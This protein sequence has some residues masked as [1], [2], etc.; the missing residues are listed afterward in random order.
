MALYERVDSNEEFAESSIQEGTVIPEYMTATTDT[1]TP[2]D[3]KFHSEIQGRAPMLDLAKYP[4]GRFG[5]ERIPT[6][7]LSSVSGES[8]PLGQTVYRQGDS[9][10][11]YYGSAFNTSDQNGFYVTL[12]ADAVIEVTF[13]GTGLNVLL[14]YSNVSRTALASVDGGAEGS[15]I[16]NGTSTVLN[17]RNYSI[18]V[19]Q[20]AVSGLPLGIHTVKIRSSGSTNVVHGFEILNESTTI[21]IPE[22]SV[23]IEGKKHTLA[24]PTTTD[25]TTFDVETQDGGS[26]ITSTNKGG[27]VV[28]YIDTD[29]TIK[30]A[31]N[32][33]DSAQGNVGVDVDHSNEVVV[34][35]FNWREFGAGRA[36]DFSTLN[37]QSGADKAF[38]LDDGTTTLVGDALQ[39]SGGTSTGVFVNNGGFLTLTF[40][41][42]GLDV[43]FVEGPAGGTLPVTV[44]GSSIGSLTALDADVTRT[45][46]SGLP[47]GTHTVR[48]DTSVDSNAFDSFI[49]YAPKKP[50]L[51]TGQT[52]INCFYKMADFDSSGTA[53][54]ANANAIPAGTLTKMWAREMVYT[55]TWSQSGV[56][57]HEPG[58]IQ[59]QAA[60]NGAICEYTFFGT[61][62]QLH[63]QGA[64][65]TTLAIEMDG[66]ATTTGVG[67]EAF[68]NDGGG[69]YTNTASAQD[70]ARLDF[71]GL[72]LDAH[73]IKVTK[74][75]GSDGRFQA[76]HVI[77]PTYSY[78]NSLLNTSTAL[79]GSNSLETKLLIPGATRHKIIATAGIEGAVFSGSYAAYIPN[80]AAMDAVG[81]PGVFHWSRC[82]NMVTVIGLISGHNP[83]ADASCE[84]SLPPEAL[85]TKSFT[86]EGQAGG[87]AGDTQGNSPEH[88]YGTIK[89]QTGQ[90]T[91]NIAWRTS[92]NPGPFNCT[93]HFSYI[94]DF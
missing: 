83:S 24:A 16:V 72:T 37:N 69:V 31:I 94:I 26:V 15:N 28:T 13:Y 9:R 78:K 63:A 85:P 89:Q 35:K 27:C 17:G 32:Y 53:G 54:S 23:T 79:V 62:I 75:G 88:P 67:I 5:V 84:I 76:F 29:G 59:W 87:F 46:V 74:T 66:V 71:T 41:G 92:F 48:F 45:I 22:G 25:F 61:G 58:G 60:A 52:E 36:D 65:T 44:D 43:G 47:F 34:Q 19:P 51:T 42:S 80:S 49:V 50:V 93:V 10:I 18:N 77:T 2:V 70:N 40:V 8:G 81:T 68:S 30:K 1:G 3:G 38:T 12:Q 20:N 4:T 82:G 11:R 21:A 90:K 55:G 14:W 73:T 39:H 57:P 6:G 7:T 33:A 56:V 86:A 64:G 91:V